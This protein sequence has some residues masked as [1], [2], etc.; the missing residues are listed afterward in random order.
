MRQTE[1][2]GSAFF[3]KVVAS[4]F[5]LLFLYGAFANLVLPFL[6][7]EAYTRETRRDRTESRDMDKHPE[8]Q[9]SWHIHFEYTD[10]EGRTHQ[11][12]HV[13]EGN[14]QGS[15]VSLPTKVY[16]MPF[17]PSQYST[18]S[19]IGSGGNV[20]RGVASLGI[21]ALLFRAVFGRRRKRKSKKIRSAAG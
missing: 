10:S 16:Y 1:G 18:Q 20:L 6:G 15:N 17:Y 12:L 3:A 14:A 2:N 21:G 7:Q 11:G 13:Q 5:M 8:L 4:V 9:Y 19:G